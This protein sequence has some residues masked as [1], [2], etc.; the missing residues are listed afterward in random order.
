MATRIVAQ[1]AAHPI[2]N[3]DGIDLR[4]LAAEARLVRCQD[5]AGPFSPIPGPDS[6]VFNG[7]RK[8]LVATHRID[9]PEDFT[10]MGVLEA[11][12]PAGHTWFVR[13]GSS[14]PWLLVAFRER[15]A[16]ELIKHIE[17]CSEYHRA[18]VQF[19]RLR[20]SRTIAGELMLIAQ[21]MSPD[22]CPSR[23]ARR[24]LKRKLLAMA[25]LQHS[26]LSKQPP[27]LAEVKTR[28]RDLGLPFRLAEEA[29]NG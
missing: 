14:I 7:T 20:A 22:R 18:D 11:K 21:C 13:E 6:I 24:V 4:G 29:R 15:T 5:V 1:E 2:I 23:A 25:D 10:G 16:E 26:M 17:W 8:A 28:M 9:M 19:D 27:T 3:T 12:D